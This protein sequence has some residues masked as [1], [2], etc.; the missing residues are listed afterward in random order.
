MQDEDQR[1]SLEK[2]IQRSFEDESAAGRPLSRRARQT[3]RTLEAYLKG[4][5]LPRYMERLREIETAIGDQR[6][7]LERA[8][9]A[10]QEESAG[11]ADEFARRWRAH[12]RAQSPRFEDLNELIRQHNEW[13]PIE[14]NLPLD[15]R[16]RDYIKPA[17]RPYRR[18]ELTPE[19]VLEKF[20]PL[21]RTDEDAA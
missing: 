10:I 11:D 16:T 21:L 5:V 2:R 17:G 9:A 4:G 20:P 19:W 8:Y 15:P 18:R 7:R 13:Y 3:K 1:T 14:R 12:A 6:R